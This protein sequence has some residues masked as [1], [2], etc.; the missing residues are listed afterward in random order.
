MQEIRINWKELEMSTDRIKYLEKQI[1]HH[2]D[3]YWNKNAPEISDE[4]Y[5][6]LVNEI[7]LIDPKNVVPFEFS[8]KIVG[9]PVKHDPPMLSMDKVY[10][11]DEVKQVVDKWECDTVTISYKMDGAACSILYKNGRIVRAA[12][13]GKGSVG[14]DITQAVLFIENVPRTIP[15]KQKVEIRGEVVMPNS[16]FDKHFKDQYAHPRNLA[17]GTLKREKPSKEESRG[18]KFYAYNV[19]HTDVKN[20]IDKFKFLKSQGFEFVPVVSIQKKDIF[21]ILEKFTKA[22]GKLDFGVDGLIITTGSIDLQKKMGN[23]SH[24]PRFAIALKYQGESG[25]TVL[26]DVDWS[27]SRTGTITPVAHVEPINLSGATITKVSL[28]HAGFIKSLGISYGCRVKVTRRG[29]VI[30]H[31][32]EVVTPGTKPVEIPNKVNGQ[33]TYMDGDFLY[34]K[35]K[36]GSVEVLVGRISHFVKVLEIEGLGEKIIR[37][38]CDFGLVKDIDDLYTLDV[39]VMESKVDRLGKKNATK[40]VANIQSKRELPLGLFLRSLGIDE[41]GKNVSNIIDKECNNLDEVFALCESD[42]SSIDSI[43]DTIATSVVDGLVRNKQ[44]IYKL[45]KHIL[46]KKEE[47]SQGPFSGK[48]FVFTGAMQMKRNDAQKRVIALGGETPSGVKN[49]L[50][51]LVVGGDEHSS[52][53][54]KAENYNR[55]GSNIKIISEEE[56]IKMI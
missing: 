36:E 11:P 41:L 48:S 53:K 49:D 26:K 12:T 10:S 1:R 16:V 40:I 6:L 55:K 15:E 38:L 5:D 7:L 22:K 42:L 4:D 31:I 28:H 50:T 13:R 43:G 39:D 32:E 33:E 37:Q 23:T 54:E 44:L 29:E 52:K 34:L 46:I 27:I 19:L 2:N 47:R 3:L 18:L 8:E 35:E 21:Q 25:I 45:T 9:K 14:E 51:Y 56:F 30:P 20:E 17:A 24:H